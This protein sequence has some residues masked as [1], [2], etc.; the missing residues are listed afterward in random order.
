MRH[1]FL[2]LCL[3]AL[4]APTPHAAAETPH[5][6]GP[7]LRLSGTPPI[8]ADTRARFNRYLST[9]SAWLAN[10]A[11]DGQSVL[12]STRFGEATQLHLVES[13]MGMRRQ[14]TYRVEPARRGGFVPG[15]KDIVFTGD[16]GGNEQYQLFRLSAE[17]GETTLLTDGLHRHSTPSWSRDGTRFA[18]SNNSRNG[19]D[20]DVY[21]APVD[22]MSKALLVGQAEGSWYPIEWSP[23]D[24][25]LLVLHYVSTTDRRIK[26]CKTD[27]S[28]CRDATDPKKPQAWRIVRW[29]PDGDKLLVSVDSRSEFTRLYQVPL[30]KKG[31]SK[32]GWVALTDDIDW[33]VDGASMAK[34]G[35]SLAFTVNEGGY[36]ALWLLDVATG[37]KSKVDLPPGIIARVQWARNAQVLGFTMTDPTSTGDTYTYDAKTEE[38][39]RWT[40]SELGGLDRGSLVAPTLESTNSFDDLE[41]PFFVYT[42]A[43]E[44]PH[45]VVISIHGGPEGQARPYFSSRTQGLL[46]AGFAVVIPNVRGSSGYGRTYVSLD[47]GFKREDSVKDIGAVLDWIAARPD[48]FDA[49][50]VGVSGG[51]YG[52]Y[53]VLASLT[54]YP[55]RIKAGVDVVGISNFVTFLENTKAYRRDLRRVEYGDERDPKMREFQER[56]SPT[57]NADKITSALFVAHGANDPRVPVGEA[58]QIVE[59]VRANGHDVWSMIAMDEGHGFGKKTNRDTFSLLQLLFFEKH[60]IGGSGTAD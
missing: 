11:D 50:N 25:E 39:T 10:I 18:W 2:L 13:P 4:T 43:G 33:D 49:A 27:G 57:N 47:N 22:D 20:T 37:T 55:D 34:D 21:V 8:P 51:S 17:T 7:T 14:V 52:G 48:T 44:G 1:L 3:V 29:H 42:P 16:I 12:V 54:T 38:L 15:S 36:S 6:D 35:S 40:E 23:D 60:L 32:K 58:E 24:S 28:G 19:T 45:P 31:I 41:V 59:V 46:S 30:G 53:M 56:I 26:I 5:D 9:R